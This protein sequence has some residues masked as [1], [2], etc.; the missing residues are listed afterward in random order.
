MI[1]TLIIC[2]ALAAAGVA[3]ASELKVSLHGKSKAEIQTE[4]SQAA[5]LACADVS[6]T[7]YAPCVQETYATA[8]SDASKAIRAAR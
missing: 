4:L 2:T 6:V 1:R 8:L 3:Q 5:K 7:D